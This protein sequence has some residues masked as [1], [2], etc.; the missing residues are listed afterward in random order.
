M[1]LTVGLLLL[2][3]GVSVHAHPIHSHG[4]VLTVSAGDGD[5]GQCPVCAS[6]AG[7][8]VP[9]L[10]SLRLPA[11]T[12]SASVCP[13]ARLLYAGAIVPMP[14]RAPPSILFSEVAC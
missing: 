14:S 9:P 10:A 7:A 5:D 2:H 13:A 8:G 12:S 1:L 4:P 3:L 11:T 6:M